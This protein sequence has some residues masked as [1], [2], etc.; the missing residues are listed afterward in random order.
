MAFWRLLPAPLDLFLLLAVLSLAV[1][2]LILF[3]LCLAQDFVELGNS[4]R[5]HCLQVAEKSDSNCF[6]AKM[7]TDCFLQQKDSSS[8]CNFI[9]RLRTL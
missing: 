6:K 9:W 4:V 1:L 5:E 7:K 2:G 8:G 3:L